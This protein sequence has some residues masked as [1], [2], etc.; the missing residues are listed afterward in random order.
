MMRSCTDNHGQ[1]HHAMRVFSEK[2]YAIQTSGRVTMRMRAQG[3]MCVSMHMRGGACAARRTL[4]GSVTMIAQSPSS[5]STRF[6]FV[7][8]ALEGPVSADFHACWNA[9]PDLCNG[10]GN[11]LTFL[12]VKRGGPGVQHL[13]DRVQTGS[14]ALCEMFVHYNSRTV[15]IM[16]HKLQASRR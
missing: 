2:A 5:N 1:R 14:P 15:H 12:G 6:E 10:A 3:R 9:I 13:Q 11:Q 16:R 4:K 7:K 8:A